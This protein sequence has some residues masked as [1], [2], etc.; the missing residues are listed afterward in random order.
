MRRTYGF[1]L[2]ELV[3]TVAI[4]IVLATIAV[5][6]YRN[7]VMRSNRSDAMAA[8]TRIAAAQEKFYLQNNSYSASLGAD[9]LDL[10]FRPDLGERY[11]LRIT[12]ADRDSFTAQATAVDKQSQDKNCRVFRL[13]EQGRRY[14]EDAGK[15]VTTASCWR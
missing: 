11:D 5:P 6:N 12:A 9:G 8:L 15:A 13:D 14:A 1:T 2:I 7:H 10:D 3:I 4:L